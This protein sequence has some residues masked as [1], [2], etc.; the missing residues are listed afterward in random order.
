L[1]F[2]D[3]VRFFDRDPPF[4]PTCA[5]RR[6]RTF[7]RDIGGVSARRRDARERETEMS[8]FAE[9]E[10]VEDLLDEDDP[11]EDLTSDD[12]FA[13]LPGASGGADKEARFLVVDPIL[14]KVSYTKD[15]KVTRPR[16]ESVV[17]L[18]NALI[19][20]HPAE[21]QKWRRT[22]LTKQL[23]KHDD[24][25]L[26]FVAAHTMVENSDK[27]RWSAQIHAWAEE[28]YKHEAQKAWL[29]GGASEPANLRQVLT[30]KEYGDLVVSAERYGATGSIV[31]A[32]KT[33]QNQQQ[34]KASINK[35]FMS[36]EGRALTDFLASSL[37]AGNTNVQ[38]NDTVRKGIFDSYVHKLAQQ[39]D[40][41]AAADPAARLD[42]SKLK[43]LRESVDP[44]VLTT[45]RA[46]SDR[47]KA[48]GKMSEQDHRAWLAEIGKHADKLIRAGVG[49]GNIGAGL[50]DAASSRVVDAAQRGVGTGGASIAQRGAGGAS[51]S[52]NTGTRF[53]DT[54][55]GLGHG[56]N[57]E[58]EAQRNLR[59]ATSRFAGYETTDDAAFET[60]AFGET[61][62]R[63]NAD[64]ARTSAGPPIVLDFEDTPQQEPSA[65]Q[66]PAASEPEASPEPA[67][68]PSTDQLLELLD[69]VR[70]S[71][72]VPND[73]SMVD[74][75][76]ALKAC[77]YDVDATIRIV[78]V[79]ASLPADVDL[80]V[81]DA[82]SRR[83]VLAALDADIL[84]KSLDAAVTR[85]TQR[86]AI[87]RKVSDNVNMREVKKFAQATWPDY[88]GT[89]M[90]VKSNRRGFVAQ[91]I[92]GLLDGG[93][94]SRSREMEEAR[95]TCIARACEALPPTL[96]D[97]DAVIIAEAALRD[98]IGA[99]AGF[100]SLDTLTGLG[101]IVHAVLHP[102]APCGD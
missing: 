85:T 10:F 79:R 48:N 78:L 73:T 31:N 13:P 50:T 67:V 63:C 17:R 54:L 53:E 49:I 3:V 42:Q 95:R 30:A 11:A 71:R 2:T 91:R 88:D 28:Y 19:H 1:K 27:E 43:I 57:P 81:T 40:A 34:D 77:A 55:A 51:T 9:P 82:I 20:A 66:G 39:C 38:D 59:A 14:H 24:T 8:A 90:D 74:L 29:R 100:P 12:A 16:V 46:W 56:T 93:T 23:A 25:A 33:N 58:S 102:P 7:A 41:A 4:S 70:R 44:S 87:K 60:S 6:A 5:L 21:A 75:K 65:P 64:P 45:A 35:C 97:F 96:Y 32:F 84:K 86:A 99:G 89:N 47:E 92:V 18:H 72:F 26:L 80:A 52:T 69:S 61:P 76:T 36:P 68:Q 98:T 37:K 101:E 22:P 83:G 15:G 94:A 62:E